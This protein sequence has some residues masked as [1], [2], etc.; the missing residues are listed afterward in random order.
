MADSRHKLP[1]ALL[2]LVNA[3]QDSG[4]VVHVYSVRRKDRKRAPPVLMIAV[5]GFPRARIDADMLDRLERLAA[6][7]PRT[8]AA[9]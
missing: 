9:A 7:G 3:A 8:R 5:N 2:R 1:P 6:Q 4:A